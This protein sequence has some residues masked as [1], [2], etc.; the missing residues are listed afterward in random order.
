MPTVSTRLLS[1]R[2]HVLLLF[3]KLM[4]AQDVLTLKSHFTQTKPVLKDFLYIRKELSFVIYV[5]FL[6]P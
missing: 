2:V 5:N 6:H 4:K 3:G 1:N